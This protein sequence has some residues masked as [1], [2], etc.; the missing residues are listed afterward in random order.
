MHN[1]ID[2]LVPGVAAPPELLRALVPGCLRRCLASQFEGAARAS[3]QRGTSP[4]GVLVAGAAWVNDLLGHHTICVQ[5]QS[6]CG[7]L[8]ATRF[9]RLRAHAGLEGP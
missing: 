6:L 4:G 1:A 9:P 5:R 7:R 3:C 8:L 2:Y